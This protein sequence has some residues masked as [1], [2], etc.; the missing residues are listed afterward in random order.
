MGLN[1]Q[2]WYGYER[3]DYGRGFSYPSPTGFVETLANQIRSSLKF[4]NT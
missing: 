4:V 2:K 1:L 3:Q